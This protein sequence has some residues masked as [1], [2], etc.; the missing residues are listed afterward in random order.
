MRIYLPTIRKGVADYNAYILVRDEKASNTDGGT[1]TSGAWRTRTL[2]TIVHD[3][4]G[5]VTLSSNQ[6]TLPAGTYI[7]SGRAQAVS[8]A[9]NYIKLVNVTD[10]DTVGNGAGSFADH[11][12][13]AIHGSFTITASK[14]FELQHRCQTTK[15]DNGFGTRS[16]FAVDKEVFAEVMFWK[17]K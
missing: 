4:T 10:T 17:I 12:D 7:F 14:A 16:V 2:N 3:D 1:F 13:P 5:L 9:Q 8:V 15:T 6:V 11:N